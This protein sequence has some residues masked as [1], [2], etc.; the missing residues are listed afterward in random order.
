MLECPKEIKFWCNLTHQNCTNL[1][2]VEKGNSE[3]M[4]QHYV[5]LFSKLYATLCNI[6]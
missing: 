2:T 1:G 6:M 5:E 3:K 4:L